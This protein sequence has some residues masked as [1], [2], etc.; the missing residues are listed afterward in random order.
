[1]KKEEKPFLPGDGDENKEAIKQS[2]LDSAKS[3]AA[4]IIS[5]AEAECARLLSDAEADIQSQRED[6]NKKAAIRAEEIKLRKSMTAG[7]DCKKYELSEKQCLV[8]AVYDAAKKRLDEMP[9][10]EYKK[11]FAKKVASTA[12]NGD[13]VILRQGEKKLDAAWLNEVNKQ[14]GFT[15]KLSQSFSAEAGVILRGQK[16]DKNLTHSVL[17]KESREKT[18]S[19]IIK[20]LFE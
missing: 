20:R 7:L 1:M 16:Y 2:I 9:A 19:E 6:N 10:D 15:L 8:T 4:G 14:T 17:I 12:E 5:N 13:E 18:E 3:I 11:F